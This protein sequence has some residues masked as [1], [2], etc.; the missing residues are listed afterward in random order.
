MICRI[1]GTE[2]FEGELFC[3]N[4]GVPVE[5]SNKA[6]TKPFEPDPLT[7]KQ[8]TAVPSVEKSFCSNCGEELLGDE[9]FCP[10]CGTKRDQ[11]APEPAPVVPDKPTFPKFDEPVFPK[12]DEPVTEEVKEPVS[13][14]VEE[15]VVIVADEPVFT[16]PKE[17]AP[18]KSDSSIDL[19]E[20][21]EL[22]V[23]SREEVISG[24]EKQIEID[25]ETIEVVIHPHYDVSESMYFDGYGY[26][27]KATGKKGRL[28][29]DFLI[30]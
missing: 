9:L 22:V 1:C 28:K 4:C 16:E 5:A 3:P 21:H 20:R 7:E 26:A 2:I 15:P 23:L 13:D 29:V 27:D 25:G 24:C 30:S 12:F 18:A 6:V 8:Q 11:E 10:N 19:T 17:P 14:E